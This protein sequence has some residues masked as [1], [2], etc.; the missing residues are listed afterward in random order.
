MFKR[1]L[2][3][4]IGAGV[5]VFA[6]LKAREYLARATPAAVQDKMVEAGQGLGERAAGFA[7]STTLL[8]L[9][10]TYELFALACIPVGFTSLTMLTSA[11]AKRNS[12]TRSA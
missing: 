1:V 4:G 3:F 10:P 2:W 7:A 9:A 12:A 5:G 8:A 6:L 11:N